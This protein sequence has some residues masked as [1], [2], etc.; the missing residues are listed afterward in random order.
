MYYLLKMQTNT[1]VPSELI[2]DKED[3]FMVSEY[4]LYGQPVRCLIPEQEDLPVAVI[5]HVLGHGDWV[6]FNPYA[7][8]LRSS[9]I[10]RILNKMDLVEDGELKTILTSAH[11]QA[12]DIMHN[13]IEREFCFCGE[14]KY[15]AKHC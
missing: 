15:G 3:T 11:K 7:H 9:M 2:Y 12:S 8:Y 10:P 5:I 4:S 1:W 14:P 13:I 6:F